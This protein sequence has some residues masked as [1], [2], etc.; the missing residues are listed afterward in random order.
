[1]AASGAFPYFSLPELIVAGEK[2]DVFVDL[3]VY[4][5][6][7][8]RCFIEWC[9]KNGKTPK[10]IFGFEPDEHNYNLSK[11]VFDRIDVTNKLFKYGAG[12]ERA[13]LK[14]NSKSDSSSAFSDMGDVEVEVRPLDEVLE[15]EDI[16]FIKMDIE[17]SEL[18]ALKGAKNIIK[19]RKPKLAICVYHK[20]DD[21]YVIPAYIWS[22]VP[23]YDLYLRHHSNSLLETVLYAVYRENRIK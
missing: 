12:E 8:S 13:V 7:S 4:N 16:T 2:E 19:S 15:G 17:G 23:E 9:N 21:I 5:G 20:L 11:S 10:K 6:F 18:A 14:F 1:N 22:L 3:G